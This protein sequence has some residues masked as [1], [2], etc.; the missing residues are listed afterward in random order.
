[1][2]ISVSPYNPVQQAGARAKN[3]PD[4]V[5]HTRD[6]NS[7][8]YGYFVGTIWVNT[9]AKS[10][11]GLG[12][13]FISP[14]TKT[15]YWALL[16]NISS[17]GI[18][19][20]AVQSGPSPVVPTPAGLVTLN[21]AVVAAGTTPFQSVGS[22][23]TVTLQL[24]LSQ[25]IP[26]ADQAKVGL[27]NFNSAQ[28]NLVNGFVSLI[29]GSGPAIQ[30]ITGNTGGPESPSAGGN[31]NIIGAGSITVAGSANTE[32]VQLTGLTL[33]AIQVGAGTSTLT[34]LGPVNRAV[35]T[36][37]ATGIPAMTALASDGQLI[38]GSTAGAPA[39]ATLTAGVGVSIVNGSNSITISAS[40][41]VAWT[42]ISGAV[43]AVSGG[44]YMATAT[45]TSTLPASPSNGDTIRYIVL[46]NNPL[47]IQ[48][49]TGQII[50]YGTSLSTTAGNIVSSQGGDTMTLVYSSFI[51]TWVALSGNGAWTPS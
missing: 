23:N 40:G 20:I 37:G 19:E 50:Q 5:M 46:T 33:N 9:V 34:Q 49:N 4:L 48:A 35:L 12:D 31:F 47:T 28:F 27:S 2:S 43:A 39:A 13:L 24:Q 14:N 25:A 11:W 8:D 7:T 1:M 42:D 17:V 41:S 44:N 3:P 38:I 45:A 36:S 18:M 21:G 22:T 26:T 15:A 29:G 51:T 30:T 10:F 32:T 6:P 16:G